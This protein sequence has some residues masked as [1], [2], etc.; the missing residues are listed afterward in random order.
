MNERG[1]LIL[2]ILGAFVILALLPPVIMMVFPLADLLM[3]IILVLLIFTTVRGYLGSNAL[4]IIISAVLI[5]FIVIKH[6]YIST[7]IYV[8]FFVLLMFQ[9]LSVIIW[10]IGTQ[11]RH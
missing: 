5:Y 4:A 6:P 3:R 10:G 9:F 1:N 11:M 7:S 2:M 8:I